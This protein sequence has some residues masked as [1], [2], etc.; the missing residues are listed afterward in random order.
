MGIII[1]TW[2]ER[3]DLWDRAQP[4]TRPSGLILS[5]T[6]YRDMEIPRLRELGSGGKSRTPLLPVQDIRGAPSNANVKSLIRFITRLVRL[7]QICLLRTSPIISIQD[8]KVCVDPRDFIFWL[9]DAREALSHR[10][11]DAASEVG[12]Y[13]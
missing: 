5:R 6:R 11:R 7:A 2:K 10:L 13:F 9:V 3:G 1:K 4:C 8:Y 12:D